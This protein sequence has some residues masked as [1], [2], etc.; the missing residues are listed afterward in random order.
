MKKEEIKPSELDDKECI[1]MSRSVLTGHLNILF[2][3]LY[4]IMVEDVEKTN[5]INMH[6]FECFA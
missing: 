2:R 6:T 3:G 5:N 4:L 1:I